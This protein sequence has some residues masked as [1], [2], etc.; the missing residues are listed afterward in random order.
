MNGIARVALFLGVVGRLCLSINVSA[1]TGSVEQTLIQLERDWA[2]ALGKNDQAALDR[3]VAPDWMVTSADGRLL[4]KAQNDA[5]QKSGT[6]KYTAFAADDFRVR[7]FGETAIVTGR[8]TVQGTQNGRDI[9]GEQRFT[10]VFVRRDGRWQAVS[11]QVTP[12]ANPRQSSSRATPA[13]V[14]I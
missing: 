8:S 1:Q 14:L 11:T 4:T 3:I 2:K 5:E 7:V 12:V 6:L 9:S 10:D 13:L